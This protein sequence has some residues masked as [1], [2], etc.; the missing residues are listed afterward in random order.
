MSW[1]MILV[2][3]VP[4]VIIMLLIYAKDKHEKEPPGLLFKCALF[5][6]ISVLFSLLLEQFTMAVIPKITFSSSSVLYYFVLAFVGV[7]AVEET[8]KYLALRL[9]TWRNPN[10]NYTFDGIVYSVY[11]SLGFAL[12]ENIVYVINHGLQTGLMRA[13]TAIP[14]HASFG[15]YMG[16]FYGYAK[17][18]EVAGNRNKMRTNLWLGWLTAVLLHGFYD[19]LAF[20]SRET[21]MVLFFVFIVVVD[22]VVIFQIFRSAKNDTPIYRTYQQPP[23]QMQFRQV[24]QNPCYVQPAQGTYRAPTYL[25]QQ[26]G[27]YPPVNPYVQPGAGVGRV[28]PYSQ[29]GAGAG[30]A[31]PYVQPGAGVGRA[32]PYSQQNGGYNGVRG[33]NDRTSQGYGGQNGMTGRP[34]ANYGHSSD[35]EGETGEL[36]R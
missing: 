27:M 33:M 6:A 14:G 17:F 22:I 16:F 8:G 21:T 18:Y 12:V 9:A 32:N 34:S 25:Q 1:L 24:Y 4:P 29:P 11:A 15:V 19:F 2:A 23:Y 10:F 7:A 36:H 5:G 30:G 28:N 26:Y 31:N 3:V 13:I 20:N 35:P